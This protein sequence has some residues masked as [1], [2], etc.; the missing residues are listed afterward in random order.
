VS[1]EHLKTATA[2]HMATDICQG[3]KCRIL[4]GQR[5]EDQRKSLST[6]VIPWGNSVVHYTIVSERSKF[7]TA[8]LYIQISSEDTAKRSQEIWVQISTNYGAISLIF[9]PFLVRGYCRKSSS[10]VNTTT[11]HSKVVAHST[12]L[13]SIHFTNLLQGFPIK[14]AMII[15]V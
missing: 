11:F 15:L 14:H 10:I 2:M 4:N 8:I 7:Q 9:F 1:D 13:N 3:A 12:T 6:C 5:G